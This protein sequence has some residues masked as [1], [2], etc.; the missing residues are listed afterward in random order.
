M[1]TTLQARIAPRRRTG[2]EKSKQRDGHRAEQAVARAGR[3]L[4]DKET[5]AGAQW[6]AVVVTGVTAA[7]FCVPASAV[8]GA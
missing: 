8:E 7:V 2:G 1:A 3:G 5:K 4:R 6:R